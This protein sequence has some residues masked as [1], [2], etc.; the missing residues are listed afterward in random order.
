MDKIFGVVTLGW[1]LPVSFWNSSRLTEWML[2]LHWRP[3]NGNFD[4]NFVQGDYIHQTTRH[5]WPPTRNYFGHD[6]SVLEKQSYVITP[7]CYRRALWQGPYHSVPT[8]KW[9]SRNF[10]RSITFTCR[11]GG[12][13][14]KPYLEC[15]DRSGEGSATPVAVQFSSLWR[16]WPLRFGDEHVLS[17]IIREACCTADLALQSCSW[18]WCWFPCGHTSG[19]GLLNA[20][21]GL[22]WE[23][24]LLK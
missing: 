10:A 20:I 15:S 4:G 3:F 9:N 1:P 13:K 16:W 7:W 6:V 14:K 21:W 24:I 5:D 17:S 18:P 11:T 23:K 2:L 22:G 19:K 12:L 8:H